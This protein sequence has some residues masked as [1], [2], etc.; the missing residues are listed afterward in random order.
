MLKL[1]LIATLSLGT[2]GFAQTMDT[3]EGH[4]QGAQQDWYNQ[5]LSTAVQGFVNA[6]NA[7]TPTAVATSEG[8]AQ[9]G[10]MAANLGAVNPNE[11]WYNQVLSR[12][13]KAYDR[14]N[15]AIK[16]AAGAEFNQ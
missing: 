3:D 5:H 15:N 4:M 6:A 11:D 7:T 16:P 1:L 2:F 8:T 13:V 12:Q 9:P 10:S 14:V